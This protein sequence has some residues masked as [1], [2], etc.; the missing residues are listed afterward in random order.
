MKAHRKYDVII[1]GGFGHVGLPLGIVLADSGMQVALYDIDQTK[2]ASIA[3]GK[4]PF[5]ELDAEPLLQKVIGKS[6]FICDNLSDVTLSEHIIITIGTPVDEYLNP[7]T[8]L[9]TDLAEE[10]SVYFRPGQHIIL[11]STVYPGTTDYLNEFLKRKAIDI[12]LSFCPERIIQGHAIRELK[13]LPQIVSGCSAEA[14]RGA[15]SLFGRCGVQTMVVTTREAELTKLFSNAWRYIQFAIANQFYMI[16]TDSGTDYDRIYRAMTY[17]YERARDFPLPGFAAG[18]CLLKDTMQLAAFFGN[19]FHLG[20]AA[21]LI[22]EGLPN[23]LVNHLMDSLKIN[24]N[25]AKIGILGMAF[26]SDSDDTRDSLSFKLAKILRFHGA[27]VYCS[28]EYV[29]NPSFIS[30][31][32]LLA[33]CNTIIIGVPHGAYRHLTV[34]DETHV[35]DLWNVVRK[36]TDLSAV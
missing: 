34:P 6:L 1:I 17:D 9:V 35:I 23:F 25:G 18:P 29:K 31:E 4:M 19:Q 30:K 32:E 5:M 27:L 33:T 22:N 2:A 10:L 7:K 26:K 15:E 28:D 3:E 16:A 14:V 24:L 8:G 11:R 13:A 12:H 21:M 36:P 20:Q